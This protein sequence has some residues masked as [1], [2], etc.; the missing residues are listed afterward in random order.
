MNSFAIGDLLARILLS[1]LPRRLSDR[2]RQNTSPL[3]V[4]VL[5]SGVRICEEQP[6]M[7]L[8]EGVF[9]T[10]LFD[11]ALFGTSNPVI[12]GVIRLFTTVQNSWDR[13]FANADDAEGG[14]RDFCDRL[15]IQREP[16]IWE[17]GIREYASLNDFFSR[18][19]APVHCPPVGSGRMVSPACCK[20]LVYD[21]DDAMRSILIKG[22]DYELSRIGLPGKDL[23][24]FGRNPVLLGYLSPRDYHRVH[25]PISVRRT[26]RPCCLPLL[27]CR[28]CVLFR[29][30]F[31]VLAPLRR[32]C[33]GV[34]R[35]LHGLTLLTPFCIGRTRPAGEVRA[36]QNGG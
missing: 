9:A 33:E 14:I 30:Q 15:D 17:R 1:V 28:V 19:Y 27:V 29:E 23:D 32:Y 35:A 20:L 10:L 13:P 2:I 21:D 7:T 22:C 24:A 3:E 4:Y 25:A 6:R 11:M 5:R 36:L 12:N 18:T 31:P 16:W 34:S 8:F 26:R